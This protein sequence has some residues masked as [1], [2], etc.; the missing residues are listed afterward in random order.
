ML[1][2]MRADDGA[3]IKLGVSVAA[4]V[5]AAL[6]IDIRLTKRTGSALSTHR[7]RSLRWLSGSQFL[8]N[9]QWFGKC[10]MPLFVAS[11]CQ[12]ELTCGRANTAKL[13]AGRT[14]DREWRAGRQTGTP[15]LPGRCAPRKDTAS[16]SF[17]ILECLDHRGRGLRGFTALHEL[18]EF[19]R[20]DDISAQWR[21]ATTPRLARAADPYRDINT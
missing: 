13:N 19:C 9:S 16:T 11:L 18:D 21:G 4:F 12:C 15:M 10:S 2:A 7:P 14:E 5:F 6:H 3:V 17:N 1:P 8:F 20:R